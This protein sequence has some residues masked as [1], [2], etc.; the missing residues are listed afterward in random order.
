MPITPTTLDRLHSSHRP[1]AHGAAPRLRQGSRVVARAE[2]DVERALPSSPLL[3]LIPDRR[4][5]LERFALRVPL[6][7]EVGGD[8]DVR[9]DARRVLNGRA[10]RQG[11]R[12]AGMGRRNGQGGEDGEDKRHRGEGSGA[13]RHG[14]TV[15]VAER[16]RL[17]AS[18]RPRSAASRASAA[19]GEKPHG[20][21][22]GMAIRPAT[23]TTT[24]RSGHA[25][26]RIST[27]RELPAA[28]CGLSSR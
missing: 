8:H 24:R 26:R 27:A 7:R 10:A 19:S 28:I 5:D 1:E 20:P 23:P 22:F 4:D 18:A 3:Q 2:T 13:P 25:A 11:A 9:L 12:A 16:L 6:K 17:L 15:V 14:A 21:G